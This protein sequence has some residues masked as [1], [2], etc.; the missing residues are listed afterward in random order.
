MIG[1]EWVA[2]SMVCRLLDVGANHVNQ[3]LGGTCPLRRDRLL[4]VEHMKADMVLHHL[5]EG[6]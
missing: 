4:G 1:M 2:G 3:L 6:Y 5:G